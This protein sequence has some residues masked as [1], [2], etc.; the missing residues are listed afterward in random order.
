MSTILWIAAGI[1]CFIALIAGGMVLL[2]RRHARIL[3]KRMTADLDEA[4]A[5]QGLTIDEMDF[6]MRRIIAID[7][8]RGVLLFVDCNNAEDL[9]EVFDCAQIAECS[10]V[11]TG[12]GVRESHNGMQIADDELRQIGLS[13][14]LKNRQE[15]YLQFYNEVKDGADERSHLD[16][17]AIKWWEIL[18]RKAAGFQ[19]PKTV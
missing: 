12:N 15:C 7:H 14:A 3:H 1:L 9:V 17:K 8:S 10:I 11:R 2:A 16:R 19:L 6:M 18:R 5:R 4:V 13:L